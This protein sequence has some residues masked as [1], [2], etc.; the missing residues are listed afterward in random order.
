MR[1]HVYKCKVDIHKDLICHVFSVLLWNIQSCVS[2]L[3]ARI[4]MSIQHWKS[5]VCEIMCN[6]EV[7]CL[8]R[9]KGFVIFRYPLNLP[10]HRTITAVNCIHVDIAFFTQNYIKNNLKLWP[11]VMKYLADIIKL[12][13]FYLK[14]FQCGVCNDLIEINYLCF[15]AL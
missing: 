13:R 12:C 1:N 10:S 5:S 9:V 8:V 7:S 15:R 2:K 11:E 14:H 6:H 3:N 4:W